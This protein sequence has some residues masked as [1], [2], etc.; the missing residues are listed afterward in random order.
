M[1]RREILGQPPT[2]SLATLAR[3][4]GKSEPTVRAANKNGELAA[5][6]IRVNRLGAQYV[7]VTATVWA[8]LGMADGTSRVTARSNGAEQPKPSSRALRSVSEGGGRTSA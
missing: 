8:Y 1:S 4:L 7:V 2:M 6:G 3:C 5:L